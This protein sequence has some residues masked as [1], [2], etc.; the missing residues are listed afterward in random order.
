MRKDLPHQNQDVMLG[1]LEIT[2]EVKWGPFS[3][4][5][6]VVAEGNRQKLVRAPGKCPRQMEVPGGWS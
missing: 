6:A 5:T 2:A 4:V 3:E 1:L